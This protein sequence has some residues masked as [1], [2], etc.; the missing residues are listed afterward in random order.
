MDELDLLRRT[1]ELFAGHSA[2][3]VLPAAASF[4]DSA[5]PQAPG[6]A[7]E[8][9]HA[10]LTVARDTLRTATGTDAELAGIVERAQREH[11]EARELTGRILQEARADAATP[12]AS[13]LAHREAMRRRAARLRAQH[14]VVSDT[15]R[16]ATRRA[17]QLRL[18]RYAASRLRARKRGLPSASGRAAVAVRAALS[19]LGRPYVWGA[20]GQDKFDCSGLVQWAYR[21]A[22]I[23]LQRTTYDQIHQGVAVPRSQVQPGDLVFPHTGHVQMAIGNGMVVEAPHAGANVRVGPLGDVIAIRRVG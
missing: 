4:G 20:T 2:R 9:Y 18:L 7:A 15:R 23:D 14:R 19:K 13:P 21:H 1:H 10:A 11:R 12:A 16:S 6:G 5:P 3:L 17:A 8:R 22:G